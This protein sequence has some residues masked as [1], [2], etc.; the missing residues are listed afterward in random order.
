MRKN[1]LIKLVF[2]SLLSVSVNAY[3]YENENNRMSC[4]IDQ[5]IRKNIGKKSN[6]DLVFQSKPIELFDLISLFAPDQKFDYNLYDWKSEANNKSINWLTSG[7]KMGEHDF[8]RK[9]ESVVSINGKVLECFENTSQPC[10][11]DIVLR[12]VRNGYT[13]FEISSVSSQ[14]LDKMTIDQLFEDHKFEAKITTYDD[15][16]KTYQVTFPLKKPIE[17]KIQYTCGSEGCLLTITCNTIN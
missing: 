11:W 8:Y 14:S 10:K 7:V 1:T 9:G 12:G 13:S 5:I 3:C 4:D 17:M 16:S 6:S 15:L 2:I